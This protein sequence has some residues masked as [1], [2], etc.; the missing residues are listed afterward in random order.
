M[1]KRDVSRLSRARPWRA[2]PGPV[3][4]ERYATR[5]AIELLAVCLVL[6]PAHT[7]ALE[8]PSRARACAGR[9]HRPP[10]D[11]SR[12]SRARLVQGGRA[13]PGPVRV[14]VRAFVRVPLCR[15]VRVCVEGCVCVC[16][17]RAVCVSGELCVCVCVC[18]WTSRPGPGSSRAV[19]KRTA[20]TRTHTHTHCRARLVQGRSQQ[21][22]RSRSRRSRARPVRPARAEAPMRSSRGCGIAP[23]VG[24]L[25]GGVRDEKLCG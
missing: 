25:G 2:R 15:A 24:W 11:G 14:C 10:R 8:S 21:G 13:R 6:N 18:V 7:R 12:P 5:E 3:R 20:H 9:L 19:L 16:V 22:R 17:W 1:L 4:D 23:R